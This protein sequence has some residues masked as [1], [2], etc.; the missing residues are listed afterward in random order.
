M[1][2]RSDFLLGGEDFSNLRA[3]QLMEQSLITVPV[4]ASWY[5][6]SR[7][8]TDRGFSCLPVVNG[9]MRLMGMVHEDDFIKA[10]LEHTDIDSITAESLMQETLTISGKDSANEVMDLL[11]NKGCHPIPVV[12][13]AKLSGLIARRDILTAFLHTRSKT[14]SL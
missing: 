8:M 10:L 2:K 9:D 14:Y 1:A 6:L 3:C 5:Y 11:E 4:S 7:L 13:N 12:E